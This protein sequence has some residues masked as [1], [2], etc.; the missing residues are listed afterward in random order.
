MAVLAFLMWLLRQ[1]LNPIVSIATSG[2]HADASSVQRVAGYFGAMSTENLTLIAMLGVGI[3][4]F[5]RA[6]AERQLGR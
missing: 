3:F 1:I 5:G 2:A 6:V 4:L